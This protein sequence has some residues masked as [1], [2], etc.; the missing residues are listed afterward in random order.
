MGPIAQLRKR[1]A[2]LTPALVATIALVGTSAVATADASAAQAMP[3]G[4][5]TVKLYAA[6]LSEKVPVYGKGRTFIDPSIYV[7]ARGSALQF[8]VKRANY[9]QPL[10]IAQIIKTAGATH[11]RQ[12]G[13]WAIDGW[14]GLHRFLKV[15]ITDSA[16]TVIRSRL[17]TFCPD[18]YNPQRATADSAATS[19]YP[20]GCGGFGD[21]FILGTAWGI[22]RGWGVDPMQSGSGFIT[23]KLQAG[24]TYTATMTIT[25]RWRAVL[26]VS[27][28]DAT[29]KVKI[30]A[31]PPNQCNPC[32]GAA[33]GLGAP[34]SG[35]ASR[36]NQSAAAMQ[37]VPA[38]FNPPASVLPDLKPLPSWGIRVQ[39]VR[40]TGVSRI[41]FGATVANLGNGR[42]D[43]E[44]FSKQ[45]SPTMPAYQYFWRG[46]HIVG[47]VPA[48]TMG[49][50]NKKGHDHWHFEQ[51]AQY[52]LLNSDKNLVLRSRKVGFCIAPTDGVN[53][54][55]RHALWQPQ[56]IG[57]GGQCGF[58]GALWVQE[59]M[60][61]G[62]GD[63]YFQSLAGQSFNITNLPNGVYYI[64]IIA[65]PQHVL[66]E[67]N[68]SNDISLRRIRVVGTPGH[69]SVLVPAYHGIDRE[70]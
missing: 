31:V 30:E 11:R 61:V 17:L 41:D 28:K 18:S 22:A 37:Q 14:N 6:Q 57:F 65:N 13:S 52:R 2:R 26:R 23:A 12:L 60:P 49:F 20:Y 8:D 7:E 27:A 32:A 33:K 34:A 3:A 38:V 24:K 43:V 63:T 58:P 66:R 40:R 70:P 46:N 19:V 50:D 53:L 67:T 45:H 42:L 69:R 36:P 4:W 9:A 51:F 35:T 62:W 39:N 25:K 1:S 55:L 21:P 16:G 29:A 10:T 59:Q 56:F 5:P 15:T 54:L 47:R 64:E 48:G 44:A 68:T